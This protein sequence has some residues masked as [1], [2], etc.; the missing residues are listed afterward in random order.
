MQEGQVCSLEAMNWGNCV[1]EP[2]CCQRHTE[3]STFT[4]SITVDAVDVLARRP[5][6]SLDDAVFVSL[7]CRALNF[8]ALRHVDDD[9]R[10]V[11]DAVRRA[12]DTV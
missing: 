3:D 2:C 9:V 8:G 1:G 10:R 7:A 11:D 12:N 6:R 4:I 5:C